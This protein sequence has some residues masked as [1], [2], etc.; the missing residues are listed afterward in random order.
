MLDFVVGSPHTIP[1]AINQEMPEDVLMLILSRLPVKSLLRFKSISKY[2]YAL[3]QNPSFISLRYYAR[4]QSKNDSLLVNRSLAP[5]SEST[6]SLVSDE[7]P[8]HDLY[9][10]FS[11]SQVKGLCFVG[12]SNGIVCLTSCSSEIMLWNPATGEFRVLPGRPYHPWHTTNLGFAFD[13]KT[14]DYKVLSVA[15]FIN[16]S[17]DD[18]VHIYHMSMDSWREIDVAAVPK[19]IRRSHQPYHPTW[20]DGAFYWI[21]PD[22]SGRYKIIAFHM[23]DEVFEQVFLPMDV[24]CSKLASSL[25]VLRDSLALVTLEFDELAIEEPCLGIWL[26]DGNGVKDPW[27]KKYSIGPILVHIKAFQI[28]QNGEFLLLLLGGHNCWMVSYNLDTQIIKDYGEVYTDSGSAYDQFC[29]F[30]AISY[31]E[32]LVSVKR[33]V[34][35]LRKATTSS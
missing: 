1:M 12:S 27:N 25:N 10:P 26:R 30:Q 33:R 17:A 5:H 19:E 15:R 16:T 32:N 22:S 35:D 11:G 2:W 14:N 24:I 6:L 23:F 3:I 4:A 21:A 8:I 13:P 9:V 18:R 31:T 28:L 20:L 34:Y 29:E 7:T